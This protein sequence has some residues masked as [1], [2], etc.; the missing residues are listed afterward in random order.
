MGPMLKGMKGMENMGSMEEMLEKMM[1]SFTGGSGGQQKMSQMNSL[2]K[3][4]ERMRAKLEKRKND[5]LLEQ[6]KKGEIQPTETPNNFVFK[7]DGEIQE[8]SVAKPINDDWLDE[9]VIEK[10]P[11]VKKG[12][13][14]GK[15]GK[16]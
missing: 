14:K 7:I 1:S 2:Q 6:T 8:K 16:K 13:G 9:P 12:K 3:H 5:A 11:G 15:K 4:K 10:Q